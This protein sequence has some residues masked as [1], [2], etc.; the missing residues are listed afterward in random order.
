MTI[1]DYIRINSYVEYTD[2][3][4]RAV[5]LL[6]L[7]FQGDEGDCGSEPAWP[8]QPP[9]AGPEQPASGP[10]RTSLLPLPAGLLRGDDWL[11][12]WWCEALS[13][14]VNLWIRDTFEM[15]KV[16][17]IQRRPYYSS[18]E[19]SQEFCIGYDGEFCM[20][21]LR[22][23]VLYYGLWWVCMGYD[24]GCCTVKPLNKGHLWGVESVL[25][26]EVSFIWR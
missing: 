22:W 4:S 16:S 25:Y 13:P 12:Q 1:I 6:F 17:S 7:C 19:Q 24:G 5:S 11:W 23:G 20:Y 3:S 2:S 14:T 26:S 10:R 21:G 15:L 9:D 8:H 18:M